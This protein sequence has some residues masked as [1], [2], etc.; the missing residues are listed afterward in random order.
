[1]KSAIPALA[2]AGLAAGCASSPYSQPYS[3]IQVDPIRAAD[4]LVIPVVINRVDGV[5][6]L[7]LNRIVVE[8]GRRAVTVD[9]PPRKGFHL[10]TQETFEIDARPCMR[11]YIAARLV[12]PVTQDWSA[13]VRSTERI[14]ECERK[15]GMGK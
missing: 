14:G 11:Y 1:M 8:P 2:A 4:P 7:Q 10:A 3:E 13:F 9:V 15:F 5:N 6:A 12:T